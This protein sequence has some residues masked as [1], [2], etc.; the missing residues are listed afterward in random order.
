VQEE[1]V[2][3]RIGPNKVRASGFRACITKK[4]RSLSVDHMGVRGKKKKRGSWWGTGATSN[5]ASKERG[6]EKKK[7]KSKHHH[8]KSRTSRWNYAKGGKESV[9]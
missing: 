4:G 9:P 2:P 6:G 1:E 5:W 3:Y 7:R 8:T